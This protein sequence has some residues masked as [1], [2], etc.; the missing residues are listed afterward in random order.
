MTDRSCLKTHGRLPSCGR[1]P[2]VEGVTETRRS[3][4]RVPSKPRR[5]DCRSPRHREL[6]LR[7]QKEPNRL[8]DA[9]AGPCGPA[10]PVTPAKAHSPHCSKRVGPLT[11]SCKGGPEGPAGPVLRGSPSLDTAL[12]SDFSRQLHFKNW[13]KWLTSGE[14]FQEHLPANLPG[15]QTAKRGEHCGHKHKQQKTRKGRLWSLQS[16]TRGYVPVC[17]SVSSLTTTA[18]CSVLEKYGLGHQSKRGSP[19]TAWDQ[20]TIGRVTSATSRLI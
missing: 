6:P 8:A 16:Q 20:R 14:R 9:A 12:A 4:G 17:Y 5:R 11:A 7:R 2:P 19:Q 15:R 18:T 3:P 13:A 10:K 1:S